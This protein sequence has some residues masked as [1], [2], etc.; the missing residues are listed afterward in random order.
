VSCA[1]KAGNRKRKVVN[2]L[3]SMEQLVHEILDIR[4]NRCLSLWR[5]ASEAF[6]KESKKVRVR[7]DRRSGMVNGKRW[8]EKGLLWGLRD[9]GRSARIAQQTG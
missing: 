1:S 7:D 4:S 8:M 6:S 9:R 2:S 3:L 5:L